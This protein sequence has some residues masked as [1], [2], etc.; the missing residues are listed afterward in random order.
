MRQNRVEPNNP[1]EVVLSHA[2]KPYPECCLVSLN[3]LKAIRLFAGIARRRPLA[4]ALCGLLV[5]LVRAAEL[6]RLPI[7]E[8]GVHDEFSYLLAADTFASGR[9][10]N[11][12]HPMWKHFESFHILQL[13]YYESMYPPGQGL[14]LAAGQAFLGH[15]WWAVYLSMG[16]L[17]CC[18][19]WMLQG[20]LPP[21]WAFLGGLLIAMRIGVFSS[22]M[23]SYW[24][25]A[26]AGIGGALMFGALPR[27]EK[28][29]RVRDAVLLGLG[30][31]ILANSRPYEGLV[32]SIPVAAALL[33]RPSRRALVPV[34]IVVSIAG[35]AT[36]YYCWR[37]TDHPFLMAHQ[38]NRETYAMARF[39]LWEQPRPEPIYRHAVMRQFYTEWEP[40]FQNAIGQNTLSGW[41][42]AAV[43]RSAVQWGFYLGWA[44]S[45][46]LLML[47]WTLRD[48]RMRFWLFA[49]PVFLLGLALERYTQPH[50][51]APFVGVPMVLLLQGMRHL[52]ASR[53]GRYV[54]GVVVLACVCGF[55]QQVVSPQM[56]YPY[57]GNL[58]RARI[59]RQLEGTAGQHLV[60]VHYEEDH[61]V[62]RE[63]VYNRADIDRARVVWAREMNPAEDQELKNYFRG[64]KIWVVDADEAEPRLTAARPAVR[65]QSNI[66]P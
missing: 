22:W 36:A 17:C 47:P 66:A 11:S 57:P 25:G 23:N 7:P 24:G 46:P 30:L 3:G 16:L 50:Y 49:C 4:A 62:H 34:A 13:P 48:R 44:L 1:A 28:R 2:M 9:I 12:A 26:V 41:L 15:P 51:L 32:A 18:L 6:P 35:A 20:W 56:P 43:G 27:L 29:P 10:T 54:V 19:C 14:L 53:A 5:L 61:D 38:L 65:L 33:W 58:Q 55:V 52:W 37:T 8:P 21:G 64:R 31:A 42:D 60:M 63:W 45:V 39:F 59:L 40:N